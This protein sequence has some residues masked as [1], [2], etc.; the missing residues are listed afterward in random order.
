MRFDV[1]VGRWLDV[2]ISFGELVVA[3]QL[4]RGKSLI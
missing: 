3:Q 1:G 2:A 4:I